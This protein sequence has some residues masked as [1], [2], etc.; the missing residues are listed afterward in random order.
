METKVIV[1]ACCLALQ[2]ILVI[3]MVILNRRIDKRIENISKRIKEL[4][5]KD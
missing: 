3:V 1:Q 5:G 4:Y 2:I